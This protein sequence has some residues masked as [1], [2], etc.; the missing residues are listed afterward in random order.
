MLQP[1]AS[2]GEIPR[3]RREKADSDFADSDRADLRPVYRGV[4]A[5]SEAVDR[6]KGGAS[7]LRVAWLYGITFAPATR[8]THELIA[9]EAERFVHAK[10][11]AFF[12]GQ[13]RLFERPLGLLLDHI[14]FPKASRA[15]RTRAQLR[16][17]F[18]RRLYELRSW[19]FIAMSDV[20]K[21][22]P[23]DLCKFG[24]TG[25]VFV[26]TAPGDDWDALVARYR[27]TRLGQ[28]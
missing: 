17:D 9:H 12:T 1:N 20:L 28:P 16:K 22:R 6:H 19:G 24:G 7:L 25:P 8:R 21:E 23:A 5:W 18:Q 4:A 26:L 13:D 15:P 11:G 14:A 27:L 3:S 2:D 10:N